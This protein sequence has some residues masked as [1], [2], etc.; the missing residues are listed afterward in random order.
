MRV[1]RTYKSQLQYDGHGVRACTVICRNVAELFLA[2]ESESPAQILTL[3]CVDAII[4][5]SI[6]FFAKTTAGKSHSHMSLDESL[7]AMPIDERSYSQLDFSGQLEGGREDDLDCMLI[8]PLS[9]LLQKLRTR[10][11]STHLALLVTIG[12]HTTIF[13]SHGPRS[14]YWFDSLGQLADVSDT[15]S[16]GCI[17]DMQYNAMLLQRTL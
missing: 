6:L 3:E 14:L 12:D 13:L 9:S 16:P 8:I 7:E 4:K 5:K 11:G 15:W 2:R 17:L 1:V 10:K